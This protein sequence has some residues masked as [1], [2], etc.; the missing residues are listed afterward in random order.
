MYV[1]PSGRPGDELSHSSPLAVLAGLVKLDMTYCSFSPSPFST[2]ELIIE[3]RERK[4][5][6]MFSNN[7]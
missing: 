6:S 1:D 5:E 2:I 7:I 3:A 4:G